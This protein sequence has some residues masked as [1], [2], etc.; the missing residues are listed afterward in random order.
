[1]TGAF[2]STTSGAD[3]CGVAWRPC[4]T[5]LRKFPHKRNGHIRWIE[6]SYVVL[7]GVFSFLFSFYFN[8]VVISFCNA[9]I[10]L[11]IE[12]PTLVADCLRSKMTSKSNITFAPSVKALPCWWRWLGWEF[13]SKRML[14]LVMELMLYTYIFIGVDV[15][16]IHT[17]ILIRVSSARNG[18]VVSNRVQATVSIA[19]RH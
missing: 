1:M 14:M 3:V 2:A 8:T 6:S 18:I 17:Y 16:Y 11:S 7:G 19:A 12:K 4:K 9:F 10:K 5:D 15:I 13:G